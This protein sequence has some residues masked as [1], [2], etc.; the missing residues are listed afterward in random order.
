MKVIIDMCFI[1]L[2][3]HLIN[4]SFIICYFMWR[5]KTSPF[6]SKDVY[7]MQLITFNSLNNNSVFL[8]L[9]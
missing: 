2:I 7:K 9:N 8:D 1:L 6:T 3:K 4:V 5:S